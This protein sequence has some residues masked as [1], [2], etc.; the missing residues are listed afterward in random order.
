MD[1]SG[2]RCGSRALADPTRNSA[3]LDRAIGRYTPE[4]AVVASAALKKLRAQYPGA[5]QLVFERPGSLPIFAPTERG[6]AAFS[7]VLYPRWVRFFFLK[8]I[9]LDDP[10]RR[11]EGTGNQVRSIRLDEGA[12]ILDD[13]YIRGLMAQAVKGRRSRPEARIG[14]GRTQVDVEVSAGSAFF[15]MIGLGGGLLRQ[16]L[17]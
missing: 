12:A 8:G 13:P 11:L 2:E 4:V 3:Y 16:I 7:V 14:R 15:T 6:T 9:A 5:R 17:A 1:R 10:E